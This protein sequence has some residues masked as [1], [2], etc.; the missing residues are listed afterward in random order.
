MN[1]ITKKITWKFYSDDK[2]PF[3]KQLKFHKMT[4]TIRSVFKE[5]GELYS[6]VFLDDTL[7]K[8]NI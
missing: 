5:N 2:L 7:Y 1:V 3:N 6:Q 8:L 4:I